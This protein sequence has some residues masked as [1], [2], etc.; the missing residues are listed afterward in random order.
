MGGWRPHHARRSAREGLGCSDELLLTI[1]YGLQS[2]VRG[3]GRASRN[4]RV[5]LAPPDSLFVPIRINTNHS[6][7]VGTCRCCISPV[8][9]W[10]AAT[11]LAS[12]AFTLSTTCRVCVPASQQPAH[13]SSTACPP[14]ARTLSI[15]CC[16]SSRAVVSTSSP[17][18]NRS[19]TSC[20]RLRFR[21]RHLE[22]RPKAEARLDLEGTVEWARPS[23]RG[24]GGRDAPIS[25][26]SPANSIIDSPT[27][28]LRCCNAD[29]RRLHVYL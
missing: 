26:G 5:S 1:R 15:A 8:S 7:A 12:R 4:G 24:L 14:R 2:C 19:S 11:A 13:S 22:S 3:I 10:S 16:C 29:R 6:M 28:A 25:P 17:S 9:A 27:T 20:N 23:Y 21:G 18:R